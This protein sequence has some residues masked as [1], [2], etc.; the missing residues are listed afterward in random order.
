M[1]NNIILYLT[2]HQ[3]FKN[4]SKYNGILIKKW[5]EEQ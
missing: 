4:Y 2:F 3:V 1:E 5:I